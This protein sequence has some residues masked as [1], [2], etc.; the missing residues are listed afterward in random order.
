MPGSTVINTTVI[1][2]DNVLFGDFVTLEQSLN[3]TATGDVLFGKTLAGNSGTESLMILSANDVQFNGVVSNLDQLNI[4]ASGTTRFNADVTTVGALS[5]DMPGTTAINTAVMQIGAA[6]FGDPT[7]LE[8]DLSLIVT[9]DIL[10][11]KTLSGGGN[12]L[13]IPGADDVQF[14]GTVSDLVQLNIAASGITRFNADVTGVSD[15]VTDMVGSTVIDTAAINIANA[16]FGDPVTLEQSLNLTAS[17]NILF[18]KTLAGNS[19]T[20]SLVILA[21]DN[22]QF[23]GVVSSLNQ[24]EINASGETRFNANV[25]G[26]ADLTTDMAGSTVINATAMQLGTVTFGDAVT[27]EQNLNLTVTGD[28]LF[29]DSLAGSSGAESLVISGAANAQFEGIVSSLNQLNINASGI[30]QFNADMTGVINVTSDVPG[31]TIINTAGFDIGSATFGDD[32]TLLQTLNLTATGDLLF[33]KTVAGN[34]G[35]ESLL[36]LG[37]AN[38][39]FD[40]VVS[41]LNQLDVTASGTTRFNAN[42]TGVTDLLTD[43]P[44]STVI[45]TASFNVVNA[46]F[47]DPVT[48]EQSL[49]LAAT[50][51]VLFSKTLTGDLGAE[52]LQI[53][54]AV[55]VQFD[56]IVSNL[57]QLDVTASGITRFNAN[58]TGITGLTTDA[59]GSTVINTT[60]ISADDVLFGD[61]VI[62]EQSL[63][64]TAIG[65]VLFSNTLAGNV[66]T[67]SLMILGANNVQFDGVVSNLNQISIAAS[68]VTQFNA[69]VTGVSDLSTDMPGS[70]VINTAAISIANATFGDFVTL[71]QSL[72]LT[73]SGNVLFGK[74]LAGNFGTESLMILGA[75]NVQ[76]DGVVSNL[77]QLNITASGVTRFNADVTGVADM[78]TDMA[79]ATVINAASFNIATGTLGDSVT[80]E[81]S[82]NLTATGDVLFAKTVTGNVG[83]ESLMI[84]GSDNARFDGVVSDLNQFDISAS[85]ITI[86]NADVTGVA[87]LTTDMPGS[88][89]IDTTSMQLGTATFGDAVTIKQAFSLT[90]TGDVTFSDAVLLEETLSISTSG[91]ILFG[92][93]LTGSSGT[94]SL[95]ILGTTDLQFD[96]VVSNLNQLDLMASG[97]TRFNAGVTGVNTLGTDMPGSTVLNT[98]TMQVGTATFGDTV[99]LLQTLNLTATGDVLFAK[100]I[101]GN[102]GTESMIILGAGNARFDGVVSDLNQ[103]DITASGVTRFNADVIGVDELITDMAGLTVTNTA[104]FNV[105]NASFGD[106]V[107]LEQSLALTATGNVLFAK[108]LTG[109]LGTESLLI[110]SANDV[111]FDGVVSNLNQLDITASGISR[112]NADLIG[113]TALITDMPGSTLI[114]TAVMQ[115]DDVTFGDP[116]TLLQSLNLTATGDILFTKT[117]NGN[118]GTESLMILGADNVQFDGDVSSLNQLD[119]AASGIT[120]FNADLTGV[121]ALI[122]DASGSTVINTAAVQVGIATFGD[123]VTLGQDL[124]LTATG[125]VLFSKT[126]TGNVGAESLRV[127][128]VSDLTFNGAVSQLVDVTIDNAVQVRFLG[129]VNLTGALKQ[130]SGS[131]LTQWT[132][133]V[134]AASVEIQTRDI[135][136]GG[137]VSTNVAGVM[138]TA[139]RD[140]MIQASLDSTLAGA[141]GEIQVSGNR[142]VMLGAAGQVL[143]AEASIQIQSDDGTAAAV[144]RI[145]M[146][147]GAVIQSTT[148]TVSLL[149]ARDILLGE[150]AS[151]S[152]ADNAL[153]VTSRLG[154]ILDGGDAGRDLSA[155]GG[156]ILSSAAG[157]GNGNAIESDVDRVVLRNSGPGEIAIIEA[158]GLDIRGI[159]Q[160]GTGAVSVVTEAGAMLVSQ[161]GTGI[162]SQGGSVLLDAQGTGS[163]EIAASVTTS[164]GDLNLLTDTGILTQADGSLSTTAAVDSGFNSGNITAEVRQVGEINLQA[165]VTTAGAD[166]TTGVGSRAGDISLV[167]NSG[168]ITTALLNAIGGNGTGAGGDAGNVRMRSGAN[169]L[170]LNGEIRA[171]GGAGVVA[172]SD[173]AVDLIAG[174][175]ILDINNG[176]T[177]I[178]AGTFSALAAQN[179]GEITDLAAGVGNGIDIQLSGQILKAE[180]TD[181]DGVISLNSQSDLQ[182]A[183]GAIVP[184]ADGAAD[185]L[186]VTAE[187]LDVGSAL[188]A[189][190]TSPG[191][192]VNLVAGKT[193]II[194]DAGI[195]VGNGQLWLTGTED[196]IDPAGRDL[197]RLRADKL[198]FTSGAAGGNTILN[199]DLN[200]LTAR[201]TSPG[202]GIEVREADDLSVDSILIE[203]AD[204]TVRG[205]VTAAGNLGIDYLNAG[206]GNVLLETVA[207]GGG[208]V[209]LGD[210]LSDVVAG[211]LA[212]DVTQGV[213][214][215][216]QLEV[217]VDQLAAR[218]VMGDINILDLNQGLIITD[219]NGIEGVQITAAGANDQIDVR[220]FGKLQVQKTVRNSGGGDILLSALENGADASLEIQADVQ[221]TGGNGSISL[222]TPEQ[223]MVS[224]GASITAA[225]SGDVLFSAGEDRLTGGGS[226]NGS[227]DAAITLQ[228][229]TTVASDEGDIVLRA[230]G[231]IAASVVN[232]NSNNDNSLGDILL[233]ADFDGVAGGLGNGSGQVTDNSAAENANLIAAKLTIKSASGVGASDDIE[234]DVERLNVENRVSGNVQLFEVAGTGDNSLIVENARN[235]LGAID[236]Q[237]EDGDFN[238]IGEVSTTGAGEVRLK[239]GDADLDGNGL[240]SIDAAITSQDGNIQLKAAGSDA[241]ISAATKVLSSGT[242]NVEIQ[243]GANGNGNITMQDGAVVQATTGTVRLESFAEMTIGRVVTDS[244]ANDAITLTAVQGIHD[245]GDAGGADLE[246]ENGQLVITAKAGVGDLNPLETAVDKISI[247][248]QLT[249]KIQIEEQTG[250]DI[251][252]IKQSAADDVIVRSQATMRVLQTGAGVEL[253]TGNLT[254]QTQGDSSS[255]NLLQNVMTNGGNVA[256]LADHSVLLGENVSLLSGNGT[257]RIVADNDVAAGGSSGDL[258]MAEIAVID[259]GSGIIQMQ[260]DGEIRLGQVRTSTDAILTSANGEI[261][262]GGDAGGNDIAANRLAIR[263]A[264]GVGSANPLET[265]VSEISILNSSSGNIQIINQAVAGLTVGSVDGLVGL[266]LTGGVN[267]NIDITNDTGL[268][269]NAQIGNNSGGSLTLTAAAMNADLVIDAPLNAAESGA[270][271]GEIVLNAGRDLLI[272][273]TG[274]FIDIAGG[275]IAGH[276]G[277]EVTIADDVIIQSRTGAV[278]QKLPLLEN[279]ITP[280]VKASGEATVSGDFGRLN[281]VRFAITID[282]A[283]GTVETFDRLESTPSNFLYNHFYTSNPDPNNPAADIP[284]TVSIADD[285]NILFTEQGAEILLPPIVSFADVPGEGLAGGIAFD[286]SVE[287]PELESRSSTGTDISNDSAT[288]SNEQQLQSEIVVVNDDSETVDERIV[289]LRVFNADGTVRD[290]ITLKG[291]EALKLLNDFVGFVEEHDL[292]DGRYQILQQE[293][294][295]QTMRIV[296]DLLLRNGRPADNSQGLQDRPPTDD[297]DEM[298][299]PET[300]ENEIPKAE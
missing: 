186:I 142:L 166:N 237:T 159:T 2:V 244:N 259:S 36:I 3:L 22:V 181:A 141:A 37:A 266:S 92:N 221:T 88:T 96:G 296:Y 291:D 150:V 17:G 62:L 1:S 68:G 164:G 49:A 160:Q 272:N 169:D 162:T 277:N 44:G 250:L 234:T 188:A 215:A 280:Q 134:V 27:L 11:A 196:I 297:A 207:N 52:S 119:I 7:S 39:Q 129:P 194:P 94:E 165:D 6:T 249:G 73:A 59:P 283:D 89:V 225:N 269:V 26:V 57:A 212:I 209:D 45:N 238:V 84:L 226:Q 223:L 120:R 182:A 282:W 231:D 289:K 109:N 299:P 185:L 201:I 25:T 100:T 82:L 178:D 158:D 8:Q 93:L 260:A 276:A 72:N 285:A 161:T 193:L 124:N 10:F 152:S 148:Q 121:S 197:G 58:V 213:S 118:T 187:N 103:F 262:D 195:D 190:V 174:K 163:I 97:V 147:D 155:N 274:S 67:E 137:D 281:E 156:A 32:F 80:L 224:N 154:A 143:S 284:I 287:V 85:G 251:T 233:Q 29:N 288:D 232:A 28:V 184:D 77:N 15:L 300:E 30:T 278:I 138:L 140:V 106:A 189:L 104:S 216:D 192:R 167:T 113:V 116:V 229:G 252:R 115:I 20:E 261:N 130:F 41:S 230:T 18:G 204:I 65:D 75:S 40:G 145:E 173:G 125:N 38:V 228:D 179:I 13:F 133:T 83:T 240:L 177:L 5:T 246:A 214:D 35:T 279:I 23:D 4:T 265:S 243:S 123:D 111:Q 151:G 235:I 255:L 241:T 31:S 227:P 14:N 273:N 60:A 239:S 122:T 101:T 105:V 64:L 290:N 78:T 53:T 91:N 171:V 200:R 295:D 114:N 71:E 81:Q 110:A 248:N 208:I 153:V 33:S 267:G 46:I 175:S 47:G 199:T 107:T 217:E 183:A 61:P 127:V 79:G 56:G 69:D 180:I 63:N 170:L 70:T 236:I 55:D 218:T 95:M 74:T 210:A 21:A 157:T 9:G 211:S 51:N 146:L 99:T 275:S 293:P 128:S 108:T 24:L 286:L 132:D 294:G 220:T 258:L 90:A 12:S 247:E 42:V 198:V 34:A 242:G 253:N 102:L 257:V 254:L 131:G 270:G 50:G 16:T 176:N 149:A 256:L 191:D 245:A 136:A 76:F 112:F 222:T 219:I 48:L 98:T 135:I 268:Q 126:L 66:G 54:S 298:V 271:T 168:R 87:I 292:P 43:M 203:N 86:F 144:G 202:Q 19:G 206:T 139:Q 205:A 117:L 172:G 264:Q 263:A